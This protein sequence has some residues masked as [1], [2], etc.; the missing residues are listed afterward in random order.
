MNEH[1]AVSSKRHLLTVVLEDYFQVGAFGSI[2]HHDYWYRFETRLERNTLR[3]LA[4][5]DQFGLQ[6]TFFVMGWVAERMPDIVREVAQR[7]HEIANRG[8]ALR[9][10]R[11]RTPDGFRDDLLRAHEVLERASGQAIRGY[12]AGK[13]R[14]GR[15]EFWALDIL[16]QEGYAYDSS[17]MP[18]FR[19]YR[20][21]PWRRWA[22]RH[23]CGERELWEFPFATCDVGGWLI[24]VAGGNFF[25]QLPRTLI[26][27]ALDNWDRMY[28]A[29][30]V[31]YFHIWELDHEQPVIQAASLAARLRHYRNLDKMTSML[32]AY[33]T[34]FRFCSIAQHLG[35]PTAVL[36][37]LPAAVRL[38]QPLSQRGHGH[39][40]QVTMVLTAKSLMC[41]TS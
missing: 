25:R 39:W 8:Y 1:H 29:P 22:H 15:A 12:R 38:P 26:K 41:Q 36:T 14:L 33:F 18:T 24:P 34:C 19:A 7:G 20:D 27:R 10:V 6:A 37:P 4:L 23:P 11:E 31:M 16:A 35:L 5:L 9:G 28:D 3:T 17:L 2:V 30:F 13:P 40:R 32:E 21:E